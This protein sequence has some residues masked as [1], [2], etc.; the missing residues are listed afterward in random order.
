MNLSEAGL[1][2]VLIAGQIRLDEQ[3]FFMN[4]RR[5]DGC[6]E[7]AIPVSLKVPILTG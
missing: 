5:P 7:A 4:S 2:G 6:R 1:P 3:E